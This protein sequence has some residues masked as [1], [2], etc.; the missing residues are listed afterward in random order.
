MLP[1]ITGN[2]H[3]IYQNASKKIRVKEEKG[4][5][6]FVVAAEA[7]KTGETIVVEPPYSA[8]L[9]PDYFGTHC[10]HCFERYK[11]FLFSTI[12]D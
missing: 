7:I 9:L 6:R 8:C 4:Y 5:G 10:H 1:S 11:I 3:Q 2:R 12:F